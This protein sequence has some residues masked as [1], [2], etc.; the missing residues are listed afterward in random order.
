MSENKLP[1][2]KEDPRERFRRL[3]DEAEKAEQEAETAYDFSERST[4]PTE[5]AET[6]PSLIEDSDATV[7]EGDTPVEF[8]PIP[9]AGNDSTFVKG[10][11]DSLENTYIGITEDTPTRPQVAS[12]TPPPPPLGTTPQT[13]PPAL[14]T[15]GM[16]LPRRVDEIDSGATQVTPIAYQHHTALSSS[17]DRGESYI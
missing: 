2:S 1:N 7:L 10:D 12:A 17:A 15:R 11:A 13:A 4:K 6:Q 16:P 9:Q 8:V 14:D 3:L 5:P